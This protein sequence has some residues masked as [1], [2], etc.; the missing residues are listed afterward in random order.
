MGILS[1]LNTLIK[2][3]TN[4][5]VDRMTDPAREVDIL[6]ADM[7]DALKAARAEVQQCLVSEKLAMKERD[8]L[9]LQSKDWEDKA[10]RALNAGAEDLAREALGQKAQVDSLLA[11]AEKSVREQEA[12]V[13]Q[14]SASLKELEARVKEV[15]MRKGTLKQQARMQ[16]GKSPAGGKGASAFETFERLSSKVDA[17]DAEADIDMELASTAARDHEV[18]RKLQRLDQDTTIADALAELKKKLNQ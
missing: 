12:Y 6:I 14:L 8:R 3:N 15:K 11:T 18:D 16:K 2:S 7:E 1:R 13:D 4:A 10:M 17:M 9:R 5:L